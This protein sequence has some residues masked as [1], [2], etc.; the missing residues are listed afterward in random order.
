MATEKRFYCETKAAGL[1]AH[2][3]RGPRAGLDA[4]DADEEVPVRPAGRGMLCR[5]YLSDEDA[6]RGWNLFD[7]AGGRV[8]IGLPG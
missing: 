3:G 1:T 2:L 6:R 4:E 7:D 5:R 8:F